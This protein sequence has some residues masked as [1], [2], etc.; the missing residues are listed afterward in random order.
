MYDLYVTL[1]AILSAELE[2]SLFSTLM[3]THLHPFLPPLPPL[4]HTTHLS[5]TVQYI[6]GLLTTQ[7]SN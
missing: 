4:P 7:M 1:S 5:T 3:V 2:D 6:Y